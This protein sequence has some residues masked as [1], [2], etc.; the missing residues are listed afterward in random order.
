ME[1]QVNQAPTKID[2]KQDFAGFFYV[3][4]QLVHLLHPYIACTRTARRNV[5]IQ[6]ATGA[7]ASIAPVVLASLK[8]ITFG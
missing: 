4:N 5:C 1:F 3:S 8:A 6:R 2:I 7:L